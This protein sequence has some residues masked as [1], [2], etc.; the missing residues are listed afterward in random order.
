MLSTLVLGYTSLSSNAA[1]KLFTA[2]K[3]NKLKWLYI[4]YNFITDVNDVAETMTTALATNKS[5]VKL[6]MN[7]NPISGEAMVTI[8]QSLTCNNALHYLFAPTNIKDRI[9]SIV[10]EINTM[11]R[12]KGIRGG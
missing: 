6:C 7:D 3:D 11:R 5:L 4:S 12:N 2:P 8:L 9:R 1:R 10:Q